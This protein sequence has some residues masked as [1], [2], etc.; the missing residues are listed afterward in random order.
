MHKFSGPGQDDFCKK[1][2]DAAILVPKPEVWIQK[3]SINWFD[4]ELNFEQQAQERRWAFNSI[5]VSIET[6]QTLEF[7]KNKKI[8]TSWENIFLH[9]QID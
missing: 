6:A 4:E 3:R 7:Q 8:K 2:E 5:E 9:E 1:R